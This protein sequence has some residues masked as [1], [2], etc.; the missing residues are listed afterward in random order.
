[1]EPGPTDRVTTSTAS[2]FT[3]AVSIA[4]R[5]YFVTSV[6][7]AGIAATWAL[8]MA[9]SWATKL[10]I[11]TFGPWVAL[12]GFDLGV[13]GGIVG[14]IATTGLWIVAIHAE[15]AAAL[16]TSQ[17]AVRTGSLVVL[18]VGSALAG[19]RL[20]AS[21][22][23]LRGVASLQGALIDSTLDGICLTDAEGEILISNRQ[24]RRLAGELGMPP[25]GTATERLLALSN[26]VTEPERYRRRMLALAATPGQ[27]SS[28]E[29]EIRG[30]G[31][32]FRGYTA[33][34]PREATAAAGGRIWTLREV[35]ADRELDRMR[36]AFVATVSH[37]LRTPLTSISGFLEMMQDEEEGLGEA[38]R[39]Y[40]D[41]IRRSTARLHALVEDLLL[42]AQ[43]EA[44]R[45]ELSLG[46]VDMADIV[47]R[48]V[49]QIRPAAAEKGVA[50]ELA[51]DHPPA[52]QADAHRLGQVVDNLVSNAVKFTSEGGSVRVRVDSNP[53]AVRLVVEDTGIG[54]PTDEQ[55]QIFS[56]F[57]RAST[58]TRQAIPGTGLG[59]AISRALVEQH[60]GT[61]S[62][63]S[64]EREGTR[65]TV[66]LPVGVWS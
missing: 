48:S 15:N 54:I 2:I 30:S 16:D 29:F 50:L 14:A 61:I 4:R 31:R 26:S 1:V 9:F 59:L 46:P 11:V 3:R 64:R 20:R 33:P 55:G 13:V 66:S 7:L 19:R 10:G 21:E 43:I 25:S 47:R 37:E 32:V 53:S 51:S 23:V 36:D 8:M 39:S 6:A 34:A 38:G 56:R 17:I 5:R 40:L 63:A 65:V 18:G 52:V 60:G 28:D 57:F 44:R 12:L 24:M 58:A 41:V 22:R 35:T 42:V 45:I 27:A 62:L 49:E